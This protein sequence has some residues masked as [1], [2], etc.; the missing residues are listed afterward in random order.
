M[1]LTRDLKKL[2]S[3]DYE[4]ALRRIVK[5]LSRLKYVRE[6]YQFGQI[7][8]PG[9]SDID[10]MIVLRDIR[11]YE[12]RVLEIMKIIAKIKNSDYLVVH[13]PIIVTGKDLR[14]INL[15]H[16]VANL[17]QIYGKSRKIKISYNPG[18]KEMLM[19]NSFFYELIFAAVSSPRI[20]SL[21][22]NL[23][24][25]N[26]LVVC[27]ENNDPVSKNSYLFR[28]KVFNLR[29]KVLKTN[30]NLQNECTNL[31]LEGIEFIKKQEKMYLKDLTV[32]DYLKIKFH[33]KQRKVYVASSNGPFFI[34]MRIIKIYG[35]PPRY[36][37]AREKIIRFANK[38]NL[39]N[40]E[41]YS[42]K[43]TRKRFTAVSIL[44]Y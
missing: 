25:L 42:Y 3:R 14:Y 34:D 1:K 5:D 19:W 15:F 44:G 22:R 4:I 11:N 36:F 20:Q 12:S 9:I 37:K 17:K 6:I 16:S 24:L 10:L 27:I 8:S 30:K 38:F 31:F 7:K 43:E 40:K 33:L 28:K 39:G 41:R 13:R 23:L 29:K 18:S 2:K 21:R 35:F 26:N 32:W